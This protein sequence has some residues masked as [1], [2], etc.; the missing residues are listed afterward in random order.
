MRLTTRGL[1]V[2]LSLAIALTA[3]AP[4]AQAADYGRGSVKDRG[5]VPVPAPMPVAETFKWYL[6]ADVGGGLVTGGDPSAT[7][8]IYAADRDPLEGQPFGISSAWFNNGFDT[9]AMGGV[10]FGAYIGPRVRGDF[11]LD[12]RTKSNVE[13]DGNYRYQ[14]DP[15]LYGGAIYRV[16]GRTQERIEVRDTVGLL[17]LYV[18]LAE[19]G[20]RFVPYIGAGV[21]FSVR[22]VDRRHTT[23]ETATDITDPLNPALVGTATTSPKIKTHQFVPAA[24]A[25]AGFGYTL[26]SGMV[27]DFSYRFAYIGSAETSMQI[28][29][30]TSRLS[31]DSTFEHALRA[32][33]RWNVW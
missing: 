21:G 33:V 14:A 28:N 18:D 5:G 15:N 12:A 1:Q 4:G 10:G 30:A 19:R 22:T 23:S 8:N 6:R 7:G 2:G 17:N 27:L 3:A 24:A 25:M 16:D 26:D 29:N 20:T 9:F 11:T 31:I 32:G 13:M